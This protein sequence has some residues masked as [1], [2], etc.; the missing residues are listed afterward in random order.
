MDQLILSSILPRKLLYNINNVTK[1]FT[2]Y[3]DS[4]NTKNPNANHYIT[5]NNYINVSVSE[6]AITN[7]NIISTHR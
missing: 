5:P 2:K 7:K 4:L 6:I 1:S 3:A